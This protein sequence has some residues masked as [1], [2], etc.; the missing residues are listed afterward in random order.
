[1]HT[2]AVAAIATLAFSGTVLA[3]ACAA[4][5]THEFQE[6]YVGGNM[7][8]RDCASNY[9]HCLGYNPWEKTPYEE[10]TTCKK[11]T[12]REKV[13]AAA[14][15]AD[16]HAEP[17]KRHGYHAATG[18]NH[19]SS[20]TL[21]SQKAGSGHGHRHTRATPDACAAKCTHEFQE[22]YVGGNVPINEC[23][24]KYAYCLG[25]NPWEQYPYKEPTTCKKATRSEPDS[26]AAKCNGD[27]LQCFK[28]GTPVNDC[29]SKYAY[30]LGYNP[31]EKYP[32]EEPKTCKKAP[33]KR[34][35]NTCAQDCAAALLKCFTDGKDFQTCGTEFGICLITTCT[36]QSKTTEPAK[37][38]ASAEGCAKDCSAALVKCLADGK[39]FQTCRNEF[40]V[41]I[42]TTCGSQAKTA[43]EPVK[44]DANAGSCAKDC[45]D[46]LVK[47]FSEGKDLQ[48]CGTE[49]GVCLITTCASQTKS[50]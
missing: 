20:G 43:V 16:A 45:A 4:K 1:M 38:D 21:H 18:L 7:P 49:F 40:G 5:C 37:R 29:A 36:S 28:D 48:T 39:D 23:A 9:A 8:I 12:K 46:A 25:Y 50:A 17:E 10:P 2:S 15:A 34:D 35:A 41:C 3:D 44:R 42:L 24:S 14:A 32:Y 26:C 27:F 6:C 13:E 30:C 11:A 31:F 33:A 22:C 19:G 47:C